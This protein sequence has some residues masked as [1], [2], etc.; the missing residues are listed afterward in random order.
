[1]HLKLGVTKDTQRALLTAAIRLN[2]TSGP[3][4]DHIKDFL[5]AELN[6]LDV[7]NRTTEKIER[8]RQQQGQAQAFATLL[9]L[10]ENADIHLKNLEMPPAP[11][12]RQ[13]F[14]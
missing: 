4:L 3:D 1:M 8:L 11:K 10:L 9:S 5:R 14:L 12:P 6:R 2:T 7:S 13:P